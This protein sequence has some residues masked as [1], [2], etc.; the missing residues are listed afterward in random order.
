MAPSLSSTVVFGSL[1]CRKATAGV[2]QA[3]SPRVGETGQIQ[4]SLGLLGQF[5]APAAAEDVMGWPYG[6]AMTGSFF[7]SGSEWGLLFPSLG[8]W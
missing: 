1:W 8:S 6:R 2:G 5:E 7:L 3:L 4:T